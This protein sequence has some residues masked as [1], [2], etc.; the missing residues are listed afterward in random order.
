MPRMKNVKYVFL[1]PILSDSDAQKKRPP[2]LNSESR[3]VKP[4]AM[5]AIV[6]FWATVSALKPTSGSPMSLAAK[7]SCSIGE[8]MPITPIPADTFRQ[9][10]HQISQN[11]GV[12][13]ALSRWT[14]LFE[15]IAFDFEG[16]VQP[17]GAQFGGAMR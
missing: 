4:A 5:P 16:A 15:I 2:M 11:C 13:C 8:A 3:P 14:L 7:I 1:R 10:T 9:S 17:S 12:L 6:A